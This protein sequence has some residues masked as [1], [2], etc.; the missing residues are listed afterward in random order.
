[1]VLVKKA[2]YRRNGWTNAS[3]VVDG[4]TATPAE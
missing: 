1:M 4:V 2:S 3:T